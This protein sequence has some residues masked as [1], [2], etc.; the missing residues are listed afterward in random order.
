M[1]KKFRQT[2]H[3][4]VAICVQKELSC[5]SFSFRWTVS[6]LFVVLGFFCMILGIRV[7]K[8]LLSQGLNLNNRR[9]GK[10]ADFFGVV[11]EL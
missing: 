7:T 4:C 3:V 1:N 10:C 8:V 11:P 6:D 9:K 5:L 2:K